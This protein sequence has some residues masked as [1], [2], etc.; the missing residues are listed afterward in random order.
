MTATLENPTALEN[1]DLVGVVD[2]GKPVG[3]DKAR[4]V[5]HEVV[6]RLLDQ[7]LG[8]GVHA[9]GRLVEN[10]D[11]RVFQEG[12][13]DRE[14]LLLA[15]AEFHP[16]LAELRVETLGETPDEILGVRSAEGLPHFLLGGFGLADAEVLGS[17]AV[18]K[19]TLLR[20]DGDVV[21]QVVLR[22]VAQ[23]GAV[24]RDLPAGKFI[25]T[26]R[27]YETMLSVKTTICTNAPTPGKA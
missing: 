27:G 19:K 26:E 7:A 4:A 14:A 3:D 24:D 8:G 1:E 25:E 11:R 5:F 18:E 10:Q 17:G 23:R 15:D 21:A 22:N 13:G 20:H 12:A 16:A 2:G 9:R 6:E